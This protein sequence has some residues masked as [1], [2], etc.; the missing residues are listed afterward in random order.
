MREKWRKSLISSPCGWGKWHVLEALCCLLFSSFPGSVL[1]SVALFCSSETTP[2]VCWVIAWA[3]WES[4]YPSPCWI[5]T[6]F[7]AGV[8]VFLLLL[9]VMR[10][11][12]RRERK[13]SLPSYT[14]AAVNGESSTLSILGRSHLLKLCFL[15][16]LFFSC[17]NKSKLMQK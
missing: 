9:N 11:C 13:K 6:T 1:V 5:V 7:H 12:W 14:V 17:W 2:V 10:W 8:L 15:P 16:R 4:A 3:W